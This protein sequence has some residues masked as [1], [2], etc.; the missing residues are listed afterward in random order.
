MA[1]DNRKTY[2]EDI[3]RFPLRSKTQ[4]DRMRGKHM[5]MTFEL[6][7]NQ[8]YNDRITNLVTHYRPSNR[9]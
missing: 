4:K 2:L 7:N 8:E 9:M 5:L 3:L 1:S 6:K